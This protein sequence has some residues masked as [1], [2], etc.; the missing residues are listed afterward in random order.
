MGACSSGAHQRLDSLPDWTVPRPPARPRRA[1]PARGAPGQPW[2]W[3]FAGI[4]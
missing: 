1:A 2:F 3:W 4:L